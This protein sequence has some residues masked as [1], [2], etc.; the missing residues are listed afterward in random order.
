MES[1][2]KFVPLPKIDFYHIIWNLFLT[3]RDSD[4]SLDDLTSNNIHLVVTIM[5]PERFDEYR[6]KLLSDYK[7]IEVY[8]MFYNGHNM[9]LTEEMI[10]DYE[11][12]CNKLLSLQQRRRNAI[13]CCNNGYQRSL[14]FLCYYLTK[15]HNDEVPNYTKALDIILPQVCPKDYIT[16]KD[17]ILE[18]TTKILEQH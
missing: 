14:P 11:L 7:K 4:L 16:K 17:S 9:T 5:P 6:Q 15:Y 10:D 12:V 13:I 8:N 1:F 18:S 2:C 3:D